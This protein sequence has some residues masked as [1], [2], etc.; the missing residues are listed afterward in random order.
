MPPKRKEKVTMPPKKRHRSNS[1]SDNEP[2]VE[3]IVVGQSLDTYKTLSKKSVFV[4]SVL[5]WHF[6]AV[7]H[8]VKRKISA[9]ESFQSPW[10]IC[11]QREMYVNFFVEWYRAV[12]D[13]VRQVGIRKPKPI[14]D[15]RGVV[16]SYELNFTVY[17]VFEFHVS[18]IMNSDVDSYFKKELANGCHGSVIINDEKPCIIKY[19]CKRS[20]LTL[21]LFYEVTNKYGTVISY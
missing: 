14:K 16:K 5:M 2:V 6:S 15:K 12:R 4:S 10:Q 17:R 13:H 21:N 19:N 20:I 1:D 3:P 11:I 18:E 8:S 7:F 9:K